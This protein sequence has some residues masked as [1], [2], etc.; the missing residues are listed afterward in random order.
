MVF[1]K[2]IPAI[3]NSFIDGKKSIRCL[4]QNNYDK[5]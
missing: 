1:E 4:K 3:A 2:R 5:F